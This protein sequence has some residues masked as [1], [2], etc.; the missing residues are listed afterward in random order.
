MK[1]TIVLVA[2]MFFASIT[3]FSN[4]SCCQDCFTP[5]EKTYITEDQV[6]L[7]G[8]EIFVKFGDQIIQTNGL[9]ADG[10]GI[11]IVSF[12]DGKQGCPNGQDQCPN[13]RCKKC[14][15]QGYIRCPHCDTTMR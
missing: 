14:V 4:E 2:V 10:L 5:C 1:N 11:F 6:S 9:F 13:P 8:S 3:G 7:V 15:Y 12:K